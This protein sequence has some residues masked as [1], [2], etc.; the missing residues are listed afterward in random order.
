MTIY[1]GAQCLIARMIALTPFGLAL[2]LGVTCSTAALADGYTLTGT[3]GGTFQVDS[4]PLLHK[5]GVQTLLGWTSSPQLLLTGRTPALTLDFSTRVDDN[6]F[7]LSEFDSTDLHNAL[8]AKYQGERYYLSMQGL[9]DYDTTRTSEF[10]T[11]GRN[12]AG[13]RHTGFSLSPEFGYNISPV[14]LISVMANYSAGF[15]D[16][17]QDFTD[18][19]AYSLQPRYS[20][21]F[22]LRDTGFVALQASH[23]NTLSGNYNESNSVGPLVGWIHRFSDKFTTAADVG[24]HIIH[25]IENHN[26]SSWVND[27]LY[28]FSLTYGDVGDPDIVRLAVQRALQPE[29]TAT[30]VTATSVSLKETHHFTP[31]FAAVLYALY[32][33]KDYNNFQSSGKQKDYVEASAAL[34]YNVTQE[35]VVG[36]SYRF[37][38]QTTVGGGDNASGHTVLLTLTYS[39]NMTL[40]HW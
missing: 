4:N 16:N 20:Y 34:Q 2:S 24:Y 25:N 31:R 22:T 13:V 5:K 35:L 29:S 39:P 26:G 6:R 17:H 12:V 30:Q 21:T 28:D 19:E 40:L 9:F 1:G 23:F 37:R 11:S 36:T 8:G 14:Q 38:H 3:V 18:F 15:Y 10:T 7:N 33:N 32:R 27:Y